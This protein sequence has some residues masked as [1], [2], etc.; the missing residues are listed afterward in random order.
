MRVGT[1][2]LRVGVASLVSVQR[3]LRQPRLGWFL[4]QSQDNEVL[5]HFS[6]R[7]DRSL[8]KKL[9]E[10]HGSRT[11]CEPRSKKDQNPAGS[12][13]LRI[14]NLKMELEVLLQMRVSPQCVGHTRT[15]S[16]PGHRVGQRV[17]RHK[18]RFH[19]KENAQ[20]SKCNYAIKCFFDALVARDG[21]KSDCTVRVWWTHSVC[22]ASWVSRSS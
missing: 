4:L 19:K 15:S 2:V 20:S 11:V 10:L 17:Q 7:H 14:S 3:E 16:N 21:T 1:A 5:S 9:F 6:G 8:K 22:L 18:H 13:R 12:S